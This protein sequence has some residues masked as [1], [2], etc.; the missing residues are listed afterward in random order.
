MSTIKLEP[1]WTNATLLTELERCA[2]DVQRYGARSL[3]SWACQA[4]SSNRPELLAQH[5]LMR[6]LRSLADGKPPHR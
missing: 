6:R 5:D 2:I 4:T 1:N 3:A